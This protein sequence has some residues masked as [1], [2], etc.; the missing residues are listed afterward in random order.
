MF[1]HPNPRSIRILPALLVFAA[2]AALPACDGVGADPV[3]PISEVSIEFG[4]EA[5]IVGETVSVRAFVTDSDGIPA[6]GATVRW[7]VSEG[8]VTPQASTTDLEGFASASWTLGTRA[9]SVGG[10]EG[11]QLITA[12]VEGADGVEVTAEVFASVGPVADIEIAV[13]PDS[14]LVNT[15]AAVRVVAIEDIYGNAVPEGDFDEYG[16]TFTSLEPDIAAV[17]D[18]PPGEPGA[19][20]GVQGVSEGT[21]R[22]VGLAAAPLA[23]GQ[24][25]GPAFVLPE[26]AAADTVTVTVTAFDEGGPFLATA[27]G[28]GFGYSCGVDEVGA[29]HCWGANAAGQLGT[30]DTS[31]RLVPTPVQGLPGTATDVSLGG[32]HTCALLADGRVFCWGENLLGQL[33][34]GESGNPELLPVEARLPAGAAAVEVRA[35]GFSTCALLEHGDA[36]CWGADDVGRLG[37]GAPPE[38][39]ESNPDLFATEPVRVAAPAGVRFTTLS[40]GDAHTCAVADDGAAY[41]W[42]SFDG[43]R[44]GIGFSF[45]PPLNSPVPALVLAP[46]ASFGGIAAHTAATSAFDANGQLYGWGEG[47]AKAPSGSGVPDLQYQAASV[48]TSLTFTALAQ[49][50]G[51][52]G[53]GLVGAGEAFC[54]GSNRLGQLGLGDTTA[55][56]TPEAVVGPDGGAPLS[57]SAIAIGPTHTCAVE[58]GSAEAY[59]WG[60]NEFGQL[61][62]GGT[63]TEPTPVPTP[64]VMG[65]SRL[66]A[67]H[68]RLD[69]QV[70]R[71]AWCRALPSSHRRLVSVCRVAL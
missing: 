37:D 30:G 62:T 61:G 46:S 41:C 11:G 21:A 38:P 68:A 28:S 22:I 8:S 5:A 69:P 13:T 67:A 53:C 3:G 55:A 17:G 50:L 12:T 42:G 16:V 4:S 31:P 44:L 58:S 15:T 19:L 65:G 63:T 9:S 35:G 23:R 54:W 18:A 43:G 14:I 2:V 1:A 60:G 48:A 10:G 64:V 26:G 49:G 39:N 34:N 29:V 59:C 20:A 7:S 32:A 33:G 6:E 71:R 70:H 25:A 56:I 47:E 40:A 45:P 57:F 52:H 24:V 36:Y 66:A 51:E 27:V